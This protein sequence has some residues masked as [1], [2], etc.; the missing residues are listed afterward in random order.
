[1]KIRAIAWNT[2]GS[3]LRNKVILLISAIFLCV[4][5]LFSTPLITANAMRGSM[6]AAQ[7]EGMVLSMLSVIMG[8]VSG[9]GS[10]LAAWAAADAVAAELRSGTIL[11][12]MARPVRRWEFLLG[13][14]AGVQ[15]L[16]GVYV[17]FLVASTYI[18]ASMGG[19]SVHAPLWALIVYPLV[20][21]AMYAALAMFLVTVMHPFV[22][23]GITLLVAV[24]SGI[25][26]PSSG[27]SS[28]LPVW[29]RS[30]LYVVLPSTGLLSES[31]F[32]AITQA[33]LEKTQWT[34]HLTALAYGLDYALVLLLLAMLLFRRR[35]LTG[36]TAG[37]L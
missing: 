31:R 18:F 3:F 13:K 16:M 35:N 6:T 4:L 26:V 21:Y 2:F 10:L 15:I 25:V 23:F 5:L 22:A 20:R 30:S 32:L 37:S 29:L 27:T 28:F 8:L 17:I 1:M 7:T 34:A 24:L 36:G 33:S 12:V 11:A 19:E 9:F 14:F